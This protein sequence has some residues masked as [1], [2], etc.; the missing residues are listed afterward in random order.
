MAT[1]T[2]SAAYPSRRSLRLHLRVTRCLVLLH[3]LL[4]MIGE[5]RADAKETLA[6]ARAAY[7]SL[8][9]EG[10]ASF[11][12]QPQFTRA[13]KGLLLSTVQAEYRPLPSGAPASLQMRID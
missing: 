11:V 5:A 8:R 9:R 10:L 13:A 1:D 6:E 7:Y 4:P 12:L 2:T 3:S